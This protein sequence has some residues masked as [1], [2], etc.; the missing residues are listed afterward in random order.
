MK[1]KKKNASEAS[2]A[3]EEEEKKLAI[4][5]NDELCNINQ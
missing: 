1:T 4:R 3:T 5:P 2:R